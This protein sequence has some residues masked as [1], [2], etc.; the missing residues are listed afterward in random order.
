MPE[1]LMAHVAR[2]GGDPESE[3]VVVG[4]TMGGQ[5]AELALDDGTVWTF[6]AAEL[7]DAIEPK[8]EVRAA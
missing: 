6:H 1:L 5:M 8:Q 2:A 3:P 7:R 4:L